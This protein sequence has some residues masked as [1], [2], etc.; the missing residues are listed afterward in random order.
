MVEGWHYNFV[1]DEHLE[2]TKA[3][4]LR[5]F[6]RQLLTGDTVDNIP[7]LHGIGPVKANGMLA[8][9]EFEEDYNLIVLDAYM[10]Y[11]PHC[12]RE[13]VINHI[14]IIGRLLYIRRKEGEEWSFAME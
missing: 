6:Y 14:N 11:F 13:E 9:C 3:E 1:K 7:G 2:V 10:D 12:S 8:G 4:G 5:N